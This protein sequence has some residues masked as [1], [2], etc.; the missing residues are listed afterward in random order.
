MTSEL[1]DFLE[2]R[3]A[4]LA[5]SEPSASKTRE[6][7]AKWNPGIDLPTKDIVALASFYKARMGWTGCP[8]HLKR[9]AAKWLTA[10]GFTLEP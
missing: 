9:E 4:F 7:L 1:A 2:A 8:P 3:R 10:N 5:D 6:F